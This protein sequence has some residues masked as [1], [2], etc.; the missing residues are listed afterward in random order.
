M[1]IQT[2]GLSG[3]ANAE[4]SITCIENMNEFREAIFA[5]KRALG[6]QPGVVMPV[7]IVGAG[8]DVLYSENPSD[9]APLVVAAANNEQLVKSLAVFERI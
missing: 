8:K 5:A 3:L 1:A 9:T 6:G 2:A 7:G 4:L